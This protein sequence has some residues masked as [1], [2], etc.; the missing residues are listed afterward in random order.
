MIY[1]HN[2]SVCRRN[3]T[4]VH[5][6]D[7]F[8]T[9]FKPYRFGAPLLGNSITFLHGH[10]SRINSI[11]GKNRSKQNKKDAD[12]NYD[13]QFG[14]LKVGSSGENNVKYGWQYWVVPIFHEVLY[15]FFTWHYEL[16]NHKLLIT[17][18]ARILRNRKILSEY[19]ES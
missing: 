17:V 19:I 7:L 12:V 10:G 13:C 3:G 2:I 15:L 4:I 11:P 6:K 14:L 18:M 16:V 1:F 8:R 9:G 5:C